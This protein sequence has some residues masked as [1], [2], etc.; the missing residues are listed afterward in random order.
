MLEQSA[1]SRA[2]LIIFTISDLR[3]LSFATPRNAFNARI[4]VRTRGYVLNIGIGL[5]LSWDDEF[6][7]TIFIPKGIFGRDLNSN[8][9]PTLR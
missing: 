6:S 4:C 8:E 1:M 7:V 5:T 3:K 9:N 2:H